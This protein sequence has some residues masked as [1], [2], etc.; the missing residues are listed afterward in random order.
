MPPRQSATASQKRMQRYLQA[1]PKG[2]EY[3]VNFQEPLLP[4]EVED[5]NKSFAKTM[6]KGSSAV[7]SAEFTENLGTLVFKDVA[8]LKVRRDYL[9][10]CLKGILSEA[11]LKKLRYTVEPKGEASIRQERSRSPVLASQSPGAT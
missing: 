5:I 1:L 10:R 7:T 11:R 2:T 3:T 9:A 8:H 4:N 6:Q